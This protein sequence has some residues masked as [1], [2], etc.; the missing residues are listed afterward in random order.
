MSVEDQ[1]A[2]STSTSAPAPVAIPGGGETIPSEM[3]GLGGK[4][5]ESFAG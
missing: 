4:G 5:A 1:P 3:G 2:A